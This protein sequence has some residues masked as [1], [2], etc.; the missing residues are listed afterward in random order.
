MITEQTI[1]ETDQPSRCE[2]LIRR[3]AAIQTL[4]HAGGAIY[5]LIGP[6]DQGE[7]RTLCHAMRI[8]LRE[9]ED[10][11]SPRIVVDPAEEQDG[12]H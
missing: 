10:V 4:S 3:L 8:V 5:D 7:P 9:I 1:P 11:C 6:M 12:P 2:L